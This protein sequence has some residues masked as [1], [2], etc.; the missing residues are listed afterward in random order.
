MVGADG[1]RRGKLQHAGRARAEDHLIKQLSLPVE[2]P[3]RDA[4]GRAATRA[5]V[6][7]STRR[8][9][10][11]ASNNR[12]RGTKP[13]ETDVSSNRAPRPSGTTAELEAVLSPAQ[14]P[15]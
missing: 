4:I 14:Q 8:N 12:T 3:P 1:R 6:C 2:L 13:A 5:T 9:P 15:D 11:A 7:G 10:A